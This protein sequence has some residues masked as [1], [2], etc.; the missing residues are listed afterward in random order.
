MLNNVVNPFFPPLYVSHLNYVKGQLKIISQWFSWQQHG[1]FNSLRE[2]FK[3][4]SINA[5]QRINI[6]IDVNREKEEKHQGM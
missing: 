1:H 5:V 3:E 4:Y 6:C 2:Q